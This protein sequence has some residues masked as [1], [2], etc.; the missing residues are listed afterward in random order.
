MRV[1]AADSLGRL[2]LPLTEGT[3]L[4]ITSIDGQG[5]NHSATVTVQDAEG[6]DWSTMLSL[7]DLEH[8][9]T[10]GFSSSQSRTGPLPPGIY[11]VRA[12][13]LA[14]EV[15]RKSVTLQGETDVQVELKF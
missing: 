10:R 14:G 15:V 3:M 13:N 2:T 7:E 5:R 12:T 6:R 4:E 11:E 9:R 8:L 1:P